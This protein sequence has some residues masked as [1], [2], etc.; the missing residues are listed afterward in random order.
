ML[1]LRTNGVER[2]T[3]LTSR[4]PEGRSRVSN[5]NGLFV[6]RIDGRSLWARRFRDLIE[7]HVTD[8]GGPDTCS[9]GQCSLIRRIATLET[10]LERL[11]CKWAKK[12]GCTDMSELDLYQRLSNTLR[13]HLVVIG[14]ERKARR[15]VA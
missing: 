3:S 9:E 15:W 12:G 1:M 6:E 14:L 11:E 10:E 7:L 2:S 13:R 4:K 5:G 8:L